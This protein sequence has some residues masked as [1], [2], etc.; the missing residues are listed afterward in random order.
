MQQVGTRPPIDI[1]QPTQ[2]PCT[3]VNHQNRPQMRLRSASDGKLDGPG[4]LLAAMWLPRPAPRL[5]LGALAPNPWNQP[6]REAICWSRMSR[7]QTACSDVSDFPAPLATATPMTRMRLAHQRLP[8]FTGMTPPMPQR[9]PCRQWRTSMAALPPAS[10][11]LEADDAGSRHSHQLDA[12]CQHSGSRTPTA[13]RGGQPASRGLNGPP[14]C[15]LRCGRAATATGPDHPVLRVTSLLGTAAIFPEP[16]LSPKCS[17]DW[18]HFPSFPPVS[19]SKR[20][21]TSLLGTDANPCTR[22]RHHIR[23]PERHLTASDGPWTTCTAPDGPRMITCL[24]V[25]GMWLQLGCGHTLPDFPF[26]NSRRNRL[27]C[28]G[29]RSSRSPGLKLLAPMQLQC[30]RPRTGFRP[31]SRPRS[32]DG[33]A[34]GGR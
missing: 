23:L 32:L 34:T 28:E 27:F 6:L 1:R 26:R 24:H 5:P 19:R 16:T 12:E 2:N 30:R 25:A 18:L 4:K 8:L 13:C 22:V 31:D 15:L 21:P 10:P 7:P 11:R 33:R 9:S 3:R 14:N 17:Q 29:P 20:P